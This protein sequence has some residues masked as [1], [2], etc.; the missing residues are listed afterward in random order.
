MKAPVVLK[1]Y[2]NRRIYDPSRS[3]YVT[4]ADVRDMLQAGEDIQVVDA[5]TGED[6]TKTVLVQLILEGEA[7][8]EALPLDFLKQVVRVANSPAREFFSRS[9]ASFVQPFWELQKATGRTLMEAQRDFQQNWQAQMAQQMQQLQQM[10]QQWAMAATA[11]PLGFFQNPF[12]FFTP[13]P[14]R[15][16]GASSQPPAASVRAGD[17]AEI[18]QLRQE[19]AATQALIQNLIQDKMGT[20]QN[21]PH[22]DSSQGLLENMG[23]P[24][25]PIATDAPD[26]G[27]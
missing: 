20:S 10:Q 9:L 25:G 2:G 14:A 21:L 12:S 26:R 18:T 8:Q 7:T 3:G 11:S 19:L 1:K 13:P 27:D 17:A 23:D 4:L 5:K 24:P 6:L 22:A 15:P 16:E